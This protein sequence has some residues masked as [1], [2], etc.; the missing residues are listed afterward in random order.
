MEVKQ[1]VKTVKSEKLQ[2]RTCHRY[3][4]TQGIGVNHFQKDCHITYECFYYVKTYI[5]YRPHKSNEALCFTVYKT[6]SLNV[7]T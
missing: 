3:K 4:Y 6:Y 5:F 1:A 7:G 2:Y